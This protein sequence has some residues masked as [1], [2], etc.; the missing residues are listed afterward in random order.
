MDHRQQPDNCLPLR[1]KTGTQIG[2]RAWSNIFGWIQMV[3]R[4]KRVMR[5]YA[6]I[7]TVPRVDQPGNTFA[8]T[9]RLL[10]RRRART[11]GDGAVQPGKIGGT[12]KIVG[13]NKTP[14]LRRAAAVAPSPR[15]LLFGGSQIRRCQ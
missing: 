12:M 13:T 3:A 7:P 8:V 10:R 15:L 6:V 9:R 5:K 2:G 4:L 14:G 11:P 1:R